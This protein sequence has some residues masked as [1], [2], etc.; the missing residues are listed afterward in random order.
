MTR[1]LA[2]MILAA[3][4]AL[5][6]CALLDGALDATAPAGSTVE[7]EV[8]VT[9]PYLGLVVGSVTVRATRGEPAEPIPVSLL[10]EDGSA[11]AW[12][13]L[14]LTT[15]EDA[16]VDESGESPQGYL[17]PEDDLVMVATAADGA[18]I[19]SVSITASEA[20]GIL[21]LGDLRHAL[22]GVIVQ[23][24]AHR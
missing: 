12:G 16:E 19:A 4:C 17:D 3:F 8:P 23:I 24:G 6:G 7:V 2:A 5:L 21:V 9:I 15:D 1:S 20:R 10:R 22:E 13:E 11:I 18:A 14:H